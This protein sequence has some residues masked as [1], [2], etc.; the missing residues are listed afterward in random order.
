[1]EVPVNKP[2]LLCNKAGAV[3]E[4]PQNADVTDRTV[5]SG[6]EGR[7]KGRWKGV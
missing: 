7:E 3:A 5:H 4:V 1:M 6:R 2:P